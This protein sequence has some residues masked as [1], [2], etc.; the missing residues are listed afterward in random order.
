MFV[1]IMIGVTALC[2]G[3]IWLGWYLMEN[4]NH[5]IL[6]LISYIFGISGIIVC[7]IVLIVYAFAATS[8][9]IKA[10]LINDAYG[11][12][13]TTED[14]IWGD[15]IITEVIQGKKSRIELKIENK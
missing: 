5:E 6:T 3:L 8:A 2:A 12:N 7:G 9:P 4:T 15:D 1:L 14:L 10:K 13:Y 11:T